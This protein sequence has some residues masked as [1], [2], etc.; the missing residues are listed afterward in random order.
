MEPGTERGKP[1]GQ[2][3]RHQCVDSAQ[4]MVRPAP[5]T[6]GVEGGQGGSAWRGRMGVEPTSAGITDAQRF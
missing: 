2:E 4:V 5:S 1:A 3:N 6:S